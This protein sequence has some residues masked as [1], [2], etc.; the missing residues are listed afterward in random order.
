MKGVLAMAKD[1]ILDYIKE[2]KLYKVEF[3]TK[4]NRKYIDWRIDVEAKNRECAVQKT[5]DA[6][7]RKT[8]MFHVSCHLL[9]PEEEFLYHSFTRIKEQSYQ[10]NR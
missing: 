8:H 5:R 7:K 1:E 3:A 9:K 6:W 10:R 2:R 4:E